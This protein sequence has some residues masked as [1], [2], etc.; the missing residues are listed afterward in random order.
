MDS[1][2]VDLRSAFTAT[3]KLA[4]RAGPKIGR[5]GRVLD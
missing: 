1:S 5:I 3:E 2:A 4:D